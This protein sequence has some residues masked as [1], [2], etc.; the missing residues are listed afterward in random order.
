MFQV[1]LKLDGSGSDVTAPITAAAWEGIERAA[2]FLDER[3]TEEASLSRTRARRASEGFAP[4][5]RS[6]LRPVSHVPLLSGNHPAIALLEKYWD[7]LAA[8]A[9]SGGDD[10]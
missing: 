3:S 9:S 8:L 4:S 10:A 7:D 6:R 1:D 5:P 2:R